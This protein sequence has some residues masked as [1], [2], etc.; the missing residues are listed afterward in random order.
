MPPLCFPLRS[1]SAI[2]GP[3]M[4]IPKT[5]RVQDKQKIE[6]QY[7]TRPRKTR[8]S[9]IVTTRKM[10][11]FADLPLMFWVGWWE[12]SNRT[13]AGRGLTLPLPPPRDPGILIS[14]ELGRVPAILGVPEAS[15]W[16]H[17]GHLGHLRGT[18]ATHHASILSPRS[19]NMDPFGSFGLLLRPTLPLGG[20]FCDVL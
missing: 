9:A 5:F 1:C 17:L 15:A 4:P 6:R 19:P 12:W 8:P 20:Q 14:D 3:S 10:L 2:C 18:L 16:S 11:K 13:A 7:Y